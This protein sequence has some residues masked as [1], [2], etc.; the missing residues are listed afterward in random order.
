MESANFSGILIFDAWL[1][2]LL[3]LEQ[4]PEG[5]AEICQKIARLK[6]E[7]GQGTGDVNMHRVLGMIAMQETPPDWNKV[8]EHMAESIRLARERGAAPELAITHFRYAGLHRQKGDLAG[9]R[10]QLDLA[11]G[12][13]SEMEMTWWLEQA[14]VIEKNLNRI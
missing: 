12:L 7:T 10:E 2:E 14:E 13:F 6:K 3:V 8:G 9:A 5:A 4:D 1:A 11:N